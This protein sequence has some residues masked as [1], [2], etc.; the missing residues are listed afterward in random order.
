MG[1]NGLRIK[2]RWKRL[3]SHDPEDYVAQTINEKLF[4]IIVVAPAC[5]VSVY[6]INYKSVPKQMLQIF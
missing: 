6:N 1:F 4:K 3:R 2:S 5:G